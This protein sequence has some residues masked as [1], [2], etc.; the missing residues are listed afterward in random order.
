MRL[1]VL[2]DQEYAAMLSYLPKIHIRDNLII[3]LMLQCGLRSGE[4]CALTIDNVWRQGHI[5]PAIY[6]PRGSTKG[7]RARH[8]DIPEPVRAAID[9]YIALL[10]ESCY[11]VI[12]GALLFTSHARKFPLCTRAVGYLTERIGKLSV[13]RRIK[14]HTLRHTYATTLLRYT[15]IRVVQML[16]GHASVSTTQIYTHPSS[17]ECKSAVDAA[18]TE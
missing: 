11:P 15:N 4:I 8:V 13:G 2:S 5:H 18:F 10:L 1:Q 6:L 12:P 17:R 7:H 9:S 14:P 16:L 3:R